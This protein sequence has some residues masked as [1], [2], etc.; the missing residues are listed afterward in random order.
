MFKN[1]IISLQYSPRIANELFAFMVTF[2]TGRMFRLGSFVLFVERP[3]PVR[4]SGSGS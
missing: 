1:L 4:V 3:K 2:P